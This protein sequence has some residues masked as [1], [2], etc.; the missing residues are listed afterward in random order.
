MNFYSIF[1]GGS[2]GLINLLNTI[3]EL[4]VELAEH[5]KINIISLKLN[6]FDSY[7]FLDI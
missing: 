5:S 4:T 2:D 1:L 3:K 6:C 7:V